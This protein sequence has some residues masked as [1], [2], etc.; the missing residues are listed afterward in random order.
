MA[1]HS[2]KQKDGEDKTNETKG[3]LDDEIDRL[4]TL[5]LAEFTAA[6]NALAARLKKDGRGD[7]AERVKAMAKPS[8]SAWAVN[9]LYWKH[10]ESFDRLIAAGQRVRQVHASQVAGK[11]ED[12]R[13]QGDERRKALSELSRL[14]AALLQDAGHSATPETMRRIM[15]TLEAM[16]A[17]ASLPDAPPPGR[18]TDDVDPPG[19]EALAAL[20]GDGETKRV[21]A[22]R[23]VTPLQ[24]SRQKQATAISTHE[25][26]ETRQTGIAAAK[27]SLRNAEHVLKEARARARDLDAALKRAGAEAKK[28]E[29][30]KLDA[31]ERFQ[32]ASAASEAAAQSARSIAAQAQEAAKAVE[33]AVRTVEKASRDLQLLLR[34]SDGRR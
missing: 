24:S 6:R 9:Q 14:A 12:M 29:K 25:P 21:E 33:N 11:L 10:R 22:P 13:V 23:P 15:T 4:F 5:P 8:V 31:G 3:D 2:G 19:F 1:R 18:L 34:G 7:E 26:E 16:S 30:H 32:K 20:V 27:V 28:A 17:Y